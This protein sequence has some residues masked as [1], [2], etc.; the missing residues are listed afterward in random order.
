MRERNIRS[1]LLAYYLNLAELGDSEAEA[2][3]TEIAKNL[4]IE[5]E[6]PIK[7]S[8]KIRVVFPSGVIKEF[9]TAKEVLAKFSMDLETLRNCI[10]EGY[11]DAAGRMFEQIESRKK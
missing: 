3:A 2:K 10:E 1:K 7:T 11:A 5:E 9:G 4:F 6:S 8:S